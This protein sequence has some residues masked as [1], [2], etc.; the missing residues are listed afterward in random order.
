MS[1]EVIEQELVSPPNLSQLKE[2]IVTKVN[3]KSN[4]KCNHLKELKIDSEPAT[5]VLT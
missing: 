4:I 5:K 3:Y 2:I 1:S